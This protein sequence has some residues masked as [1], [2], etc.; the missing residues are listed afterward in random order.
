MLIQNRFKYIPLWLAI[1]AMTALLLSACSSDS[2]NH[3][4]SSEPEVVV[5][6]ATNLNDYTEALEID[7][8]Q[9][10]Q[11]PLTGYF[12][13][14]VGTDRT[15]KVYVSE[16]A[17]LRSRWTVV[18]VPDGVETYTFLH[19]EGWISL[20]DKRGESILAL[21]PSAN[22]WGSVADE[23][24]YV[25]EAMT[26]LMTTNNDNGISVTSTFSTFYLVGYEAGCSPLEAWAAEYPI[27]VISQAYIAGSGA[28]QAYLDTVGA[29]EYD[30]HNTGG[31]NP[32]PDDN[33]FMNTLMQLGY[34]GTFIT[35]S[36]VP[37]PTLFA[38]YDPN[39]Y[40]LTY[41]KAAN[42]VLAEPDGDVYRQYVHSNAWQTQY[43]NHCILNDNPLALYGISQVKVSNSTAM[44]ASEI[45]D[46]LS[47]FTRY[48]N[49]FAYSNNLEYR[50]DYAEMM[51]AAQTE[52]ATGVKE[53][54]L[55]TKVDGSTV[56]YE[57]YAQVATQVHA[58][59]DPDSG[60]MIA[61][62]FAL[63]DYNMDGVLDPRDYLIYIPDS[64]KEI[65][66]DQGAPIVI[67]HPGNTQ[68][69]S[70]FMDCAMWWQVADDEGCVIAIVGE[71]YGSATSATWPNGLQSA[72]FDYVLADILKNSIATDYVP[73]DFTRVYGGGHSLG[74][75]TVQTLALTD[76]DLFAAVASTSFPSMNFDGAPIAGQT[77]EMIPIYLQHGQS[78]LPFEMPDLWGAAPMQAWAQDFFN[79]NGLDTDINS[80]NLSNTIGRFQDY[81]WSN[82]QNIPLVKY[83]YTLAREHNCIPEEQVLAWEY[84]KHYSF[85]R[86]AGGNVTARYFS[87]SGFFLADEIQIVKDSTP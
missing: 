50:L 73:L 17:P 41:W 25:T 69:A 40:S 77:G 45:Y 42:D 46:F 38:G 24:D 52:A 10:A 78:D 11:L 32:G 8:S 79:A 44:T 59:N 39:D 33:V 2:D 62:I 49:T 19:K 71:M 65:W 31:Y 80:F 29:Q 60:T 34:D 3:H 83:T 23:E 66:G 61:G 64:A 72:N 6:E 57:V 35:H 47:I 26:F 74:S 1:L 4:S 63:D 82:N 68:T 36:D 15:L 16:N 30:G 84:L 55:V 48:T 87:N 51:V 28:G 7:Y 20:A 56:G 5:P 37:V 53:T 85:E 67:V 81:I 9:A 75:K 18:A 14:A 76:T 70:V 13:K 21:E 58:Y 54:N 43:A 12:S 86:N 27:Y 22:G